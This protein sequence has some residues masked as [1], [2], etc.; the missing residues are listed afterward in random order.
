[1]TLDTCVSKNETLE[2]L[3]V[4]D[5]IA[6]G[7]DWQNDGVPALRIELFRVAVSAQSS[8]V[9]L[10]RNTIH[11]TLRS[12]LLLLDPKLVACSLRM[13]RIAQHRWKI[14]RSKSRP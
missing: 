5:A 4:S 13:H 6:L 3:S 14:A 2:Y 7:E 9:P 12:L 1:M 8:S 10:A 11:V